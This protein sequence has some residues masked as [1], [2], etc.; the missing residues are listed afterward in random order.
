MKLKVKLISTIASFCLIL[1]IICVGVWAASTGTVRIG[2]TV[3]FNATD[4][5]CDVTG[6]FANVEG[7]APILTKLEFNAANDSPDQ[8]SWANNPINFNKT[9]TPIVLTITIFNRST[10]RELLVTMV[11]NIEEKDAVE[12]LGKS[13]TFGGSEYA[14]GSQKKIGV[15]TTLSFEITFTYTNVDFGLKDAPYNYTINLLNG[16]KVA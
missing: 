13:V 4:I 7:E 3:S 16:D 6:S 12:D 9:A 5:F 14:F 11:D 1:A 10:E 2:G 8:S 15:N